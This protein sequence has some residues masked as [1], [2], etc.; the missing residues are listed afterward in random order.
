MLKHLLHQ[1]SLLFILAA[2]LFLISCEK[3]NDPVNDNTKKGPYHNG[4]FITNEGSFMGNNGS[5]SF[6]AYQNDTSYDIIADSVYNDIFY[7]VN[8]RTLG[9]VVQSITLSDSLAF[10][11]VNN[12][13]KVEVVTSADFKE[14]NVIS[15]VNQPRYIVINDTIA[16]ISAWGDGGVVY[17]VNLNTFEVKSTIKVGNGPEKMLIDD[18]KLY[19]ANSGGWYSD[20]T[21]TIID[22]VTNQKIDS[23]IVGGNPSSIVKTYDGEKWVLCHGIVELSPID[24]TTV[25]RETPSMIVHLDRQGEVAGKIIIAEKEHPS[26]FDI[27]PA[28]DILYFGGG[29]SYQ[30]IKSISLNETTPV[31]NEVINESAYGFM[32]EPAT[33]EIFVFQAPSFIGNGVLKRFNADGSFIKSYTLGIGPNGGASLKTTGKK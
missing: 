13:N 27:S 33:G 17:V 10:I 16:Y 28:G 7:Q 2:G 6:Y 1:S 4:V 8:G 15:G 21:V 9:D 11:V 20:S 14:Y 23:I 32:I 22:L 19:V 26:V 5:V 24:Y 30:G 12:S 31:I 25:T 18:S 29:Y 3:D